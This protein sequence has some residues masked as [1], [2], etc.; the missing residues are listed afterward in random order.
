MRN[1]IGIILIVVT[2]IYVICPIDACPGP[3]DDLI[4]AVLGVA[5]STALRKAGTKKEILED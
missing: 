5:S 3:I 1:V 4:V 2:I